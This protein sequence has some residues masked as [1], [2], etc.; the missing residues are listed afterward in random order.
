MYQDGQCSLRSWKGADST[1]VTGL[2]GRKAAGWKIKVGMMADVACFC[3]CLYSFD[4]AAGACPQC[5]EIASVGLVP[6]SPEPGRPEHRVPVA[7]GVRRDGQ[8]PGTFPEWLEAGA[9]ALS[10]HAVSAGSAR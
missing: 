2:Q 4:G 7:D 6:E 1:A 9:S 5:G 3:G 8:A 10:G